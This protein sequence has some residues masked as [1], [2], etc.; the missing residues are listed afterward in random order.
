MIGP[1]AEWCHGCRKKTNTIGEAG[2]DCLECGFSK[3]TPEIIQKESLVDSCQDCKAKCCSA[4]PGPHEVIDH[5]IFLLNYGEHDNYNKKCN[6]FVDDK[7]IFWGTDDMPLTCAI[8]VCQ[9]RE[10]SESEL[11]AIANLTGR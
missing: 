10:F 5:E 6:A 8:Y 9:S 4:G 1:I 2:S 7:C 11:N 3:V